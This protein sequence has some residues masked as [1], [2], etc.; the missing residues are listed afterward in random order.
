MS[1]K[2]FRCIL[3]NMEYS[4]LN[5]LLKYKLKLYQI[6]KNSFAAFKLLF[7]QNSMKSADFLVMLK[8]S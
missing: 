7:L 6:L 1:W 2:L 3:D 4:T 5:V 8:E